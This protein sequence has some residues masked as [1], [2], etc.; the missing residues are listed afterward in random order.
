MDE[1]KINV[2]FKNS[3]S[4]TNKLDKYATQL[5]RIYSVV[6][7][8]DKGQNKVLIEVQKSSIK[9][10]K[11]MEQ[12]EKATK[13]LG[14]QFKTAFNIAGIT[15]FTHAATK[16]FTS[17]TKMGTKSSEYIENVNLLE[18]AYKN[19]N[20]TIEQS[21]ERIETFIDKMAEVYGFDES[22]LTRQFGI[23][24]QLA[25][26]M[27]LPAQEGERLSEIMVKM[28]N[29]V[30][31]LYNLD[32]ERASNALQSALVGQT[33]P[34]RGATGADITE[35]TLQR[36]VDALGLDR[37]MS[38]LSFVEKRLIMVIS[39]TNQLKVSQGDY[40]R[41]IESASNQ[42][43][44]M[45]EQWDRLSRAVG[46]VFYPILQK[47][48]PYINGIL[49]ALT[50][51]FNLLA[52]LLGFEMPEFDYS[53]LSGTSEAALD[54]MDNI[55]GAS[56]SVDKLG[57]K[58]KG[59]RGFDKLNVINTPS[60]G[61]GAGVSGGAGGIG[62]VDPKIMDAFNKAFEQYD[63]LMGSV[64][65]KARD[66]MES[67]MRWLGFEKE[68]DEETG[69][70]VWKFQGFDKLLG[71]MWDT[72]MDLPT[73]LKLF[74]AGGIV[75]GLAKIYNYGKKIFGLI[76]NTTAVQNLKKMAEYVQVY[77]SIT[78]SKT[79]GLIGGIDAWKENATAVERF[80][81][82]LV[83]AGGLVVGLA[84]TSDAMKSVNEEGL[85]LKNSLEGLGGILS[86]TLGGAML[87][88]SIGG[89]IGAIIGAAV[90]AVGS[91]IT[92][93]TNYRS[94]VGKVVADSKEKLKEAQDI[95]AEIQR[96]FAETQME[97]ASSMS[98]TNY[99]EQLLDELNKIIDANGNIKKGYED[100][101]EY[102]LK[103]LSN[104]YGV[105]YNLVDGNLQK[106]DEFNDKIQEAIRLKEQEIILEA[107]KE[108]FIKALQRQNEYYDK[109]EEN[110]KNRDSTLIKLNKELS[111]VGLSYEEYTALM[112]KHRKGIKLTEQEERQLVLINT[113]GINQMGSNFK[114]LETAY[115]NYDKAVE[116]SRENYFQNQEMVNNY[117]DYSAAV[118]TGDFVKINEAR[119]L[120]TRTWV[121]DGQIITNSEATESGKRVENYYA[122]IRRWKEANDE[123]Y[124]NY[125][126]TLTNIEDYTEGVTPEIAEKWA[127]LGRLSEDDFINELSKLPPD[128]RQEVVDKMYSEGHS[129][130][131]NLQNG[132]NSLGVTIK[133]KLALP[134]ADEMRWLGSKIS[135][136]ISTFLSLN[137]RYNEEGGIYVNGS[138]KDITAYAGGGVPPVGQ[139]FVARENG[140]E[141]VG[142][143]GGHTAVMNN[144]QI[145]GSVA[146][147][148]YQAVRSAMGTSS[149]KGTQ[150]Y[151]IYL[152]K[153]RKLATYMLDDLDDIAKSNGR[154]IEIGG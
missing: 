89:G 81:T 85:N 88:A 96:D 58:M 31:S 5:E 56:E 103:T 41:T 74:V 136:G 104:A 70:I 92:A 25:N 141:L 61:G 18:V 53:S 142:Q 6:S 105:E 16:L 106:Q 32:L 69:K 123:R 49:M 99:H 154:P 65:M 145:V 52:S 13:S 38:Q 109:I 131:Q 59:L 9:T 122:E 46:N 57:S 39:L 55:D 125:K 45:K 113:Y 79:S 135:S 8:L 97:V 34:I 11:A 44:V 115:I 152:D 129:I 86:S 33:R 48:L 73:I 60:S 91:L 120:F 27:E 100:R 22:R 78:G 107:Y 121:K 19:A 43:R 108:D 93:L 90:G 50:E 40:A 114:S 128:L 118:Q 150:V 20:E 148:V 54:L 82:A 102:I 66:I 47:I 36:T 72:F 17:L 111:K 87:G 14:N 42:I 68:I 29:D 2:S 94:E 80:K 24:K 143:I 117:S 112:D 126:D 133:P 138:W 153:D 64:Q 134:T 95:G 12:T 37:E 77:T 67:I 130:S 1:T 51:I 151:N 119:D 83:G 3:V 101:A 7:A 4:G 127:A 10:T 15:A 23:F 84:L 63:D 137:P 21:S 139:M 76:S 110:E 30:A 71:N 140:A 132:I 116:N 147:G 75:K 35:K 144:D 62:N 124:Q 98:E 149:N 26:A 28:T 146:N